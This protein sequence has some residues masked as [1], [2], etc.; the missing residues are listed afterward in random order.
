MNTDETPAV[1]GATPADAAAIESLLARSGLPT[2]DLGTA[3]PQFIVATHDGRIIGTGALQRFGS[4]ALLRSVAVEP[5]R[6]GSGVG[7]ELVAQLEERARAAGIAQLILL[8]M[9]ARPIFERLGYQ[10]MAREQVPAAVLASAEFRS[11]CPATAT[12]MAKNL[13]PG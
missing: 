6:R 10:S 4:A 13:L 8:T 1:R 5:E 7:R 11:L 9:T 2:S 12:C 3:R